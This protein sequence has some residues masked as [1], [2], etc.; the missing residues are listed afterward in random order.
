MKKRVEDDLVYLIERRMKKS[1]I[2]RIDREEASSNSQ[3]M[4]IAN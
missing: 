3:K 1:E 2:L 4:F